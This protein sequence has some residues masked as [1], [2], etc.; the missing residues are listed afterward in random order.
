MIS[1]L[2]PARLYRIE[3]KKRY[4]AANKNYNLV[5]VEDETGDIVPLLFSDSDIS[6]SFIRASK[7]KEDIPDYKLK[8][9]K[10]SVSIYVA[11]I[12]CLLGFVSG[13]GSCWAA[14]KIYIEPFN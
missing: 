5:F 3:N 2:C 11:G 4:G 14:L 8:T 12:L 13:I 9:N 6:D 7:N 1:E 10:E